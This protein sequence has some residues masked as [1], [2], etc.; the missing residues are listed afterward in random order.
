MTSSKTGSGRVAFIGI[1]VMGREMARN[2]A[3]AG[4]E[5]VAYDI[6]PGATSALA[7]HGVE[8]SDS[9]SGAV[10][11]ADIVISMLPDTPQV[12]MLV[13][14]PD[15]LLAVP[16]KGRLFV[17]MS[18]IAP[19]ATRRMGEA[20]LAAGIDMVDA[21]VSGGPGGA[22]DA[23][24]S[25]MAGGRVEAFEAALPYLGAMGT[26]INHVGGPG[27]GQAVKLCNQLVCAL[28]I[29]A[30]CEALSL[31]R[32]FG[33]D[34]AQMRDVLKGGSANSWM[35]DNLGAAMIDGDSSAGF[36]IDLMMKDLRLVLDAAR[37][38][39][40]PL[41]A[42]GLVAAQYMEAQAHGE[43]SNGNQALFRVYDRLAG[44]DRGQ[45]AGRAA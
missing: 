35:L 29:Q 18:T 23:R 39:P 36:R 3:T 42:T 22:R 43:G 12:E 15:G 33:I 9:V 17:D 31:G 13:H 6:V 4:H 2:L 11:G 25:I 44:L 10:E 7:H 14:G 27:A 32:S 28:N 24:L 37:Q 19:E 38:G 30:I 1:G 16:P 34:L 41:P 8:A 5:V 21:P 45:S 26:T 40:V 20:L